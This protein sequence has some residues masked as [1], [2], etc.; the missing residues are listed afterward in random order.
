MVSEGCPFTTVHSDLTVSQGSLPP[1]PCR[2][3][4]RVLVDFRNASCR[5]SHLQDR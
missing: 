3:G 5:R 1:T 2:L 4:R